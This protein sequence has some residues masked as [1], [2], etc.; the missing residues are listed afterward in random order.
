MTE[1]LPPHVRPLAF[2][3][4][5]LSL[6]LL[7][8]YREIF[9]VDIE[10]VLIL[11][12]VNEATMRPLLLD[13]LTPKEALTALNPPPESRGAISRLMVAD[14]TGLPRETVRRKIK[15]LAKAGYIT[16]DENDRVQTKTHLG[17]P[18]V[19]RS[20]EAAHRAT[21]R[22]LDRLRELGLNPFQHFKS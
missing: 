8:E 6:D 21:L 16:V 10:C 12:C 9:D 20:I 15:R 19:R 14:K 2:A 4:T 22:Y 1:E 17:E 11:M 13:P 3:I 18:R 7:H 5:E